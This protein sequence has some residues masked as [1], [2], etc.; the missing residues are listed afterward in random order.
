M[1]PPQ[2]RHRALDTQ[3][4]RESR[5]RFRTSS[6]G[7][8]WLALN[9]SPQQEC[10]QMPGNGGLALRLR[11]P[12]LRGLAHDFAG[13]GPSVV[14]HAL[15]LR[16]GES[17][18]GVLLAEAVLPHRLRA[19]CWG[20]RKRLM[21]STA[22]G[23]PQA[24]LSRTPF[25]QKLSLMCLPRDVKV[26]CLPGDVKVADPKKS[27]APP[28]VSKFTHPTAQNLR[29][30]RETTKVSSSVTC[31]GRVTLLIPGA[32]TRTGAT[33]QTP[34]QPAAATRNLRRRPGLCRR[35]S[36]TPPLQ[37]AA[38]PRPRSCSWRPAPSR[39]KPC[40]RESTHC[41][42]EGLGRVED[43]ELPEGSPR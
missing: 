1:T 4:H 21:K 38:R 23:T 20:L 8:D 32:A 18:A 27:G 26:M 17:A 19:G 13:E 41:S 12:V 22:A 11:Q 24:L 31:P 6:P 35:T 33:H 5:P 28:K 9:R 15:P 34:T 10:G 14:V 7:T 16:E 25:P 30:F 39:G 3:T 43:G 40:G 37:P 36:T 29:M 42:V 2:A